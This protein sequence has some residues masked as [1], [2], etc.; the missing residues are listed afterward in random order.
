M[1]LMADDEACLPCGN[2]GYQ[3]EYSKWVNAYHIKSSNDLILIFQQHSSRYFGCRAEYFL[4]VI[5]HWIRNV[6]KNDTDYD[7]MCV[8]Q[9]ECQLQLHC[10]KSAQDLVFCHFIP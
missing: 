10:Q 9:Y 6:L 1:D 8:M 5:K 4:E 7:C 2:I 3:F